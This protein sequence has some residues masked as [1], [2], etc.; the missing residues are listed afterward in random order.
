MEL[1]TIV[2]L[3]GAVA[4]LAGYAL[5]QLRI[6]TIEDGRYAALNIIGGLALGARDGPSGQL[7]RELRISKQAAGQLIDVLVARG[8]LERTVDPADRRKLTLG[9]TERGRAAAMVQAQARAGIDVVLLSQAGRED[10]ERTRRTL[11][12][13]VD[14]GAKGEGRAGSDI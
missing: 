8:Y 4:Y 6:L 9:L 12:I 2:G 11:A 7:V 1:T 10:V 5:I 3:V 14:I 13:L